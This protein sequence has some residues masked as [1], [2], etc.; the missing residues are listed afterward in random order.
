MADPTLIILNSGENFVFLVVYVDDIAL[1][2]NV[3][4]AVSKVI[5]KFNKKFD[6]LV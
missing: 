1:I 4:D 2:G 5:E 6:V 3:Q